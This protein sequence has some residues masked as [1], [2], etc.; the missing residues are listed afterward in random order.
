MQISFAIPPQYRQRGTS[1]IAGEDQELKDKRPG[2]CAHQPVPPRPAPVR[3]LWG[4]M[5]GESS[6][7]ICILSGEL[8]ARI[9]FVTASA[10]SS[11]GAVTRLCAL[12]PDPAR[13]VF[14]PPGRLITSFKTAPALR[15]LL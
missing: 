1:R 14:D 13:P 15:A 4:K 5:I 3:E 2:E 7:R 12:I 6:L 9:E 10:V 11:G 8:S